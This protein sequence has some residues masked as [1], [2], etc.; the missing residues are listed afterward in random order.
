MGPRLGPAQHRLGSPTCFPGD[1]RDGYL[2][3]FF[4][5]YCQDGYCTV[6]CYTRYPAPACIQ[7]YKYAL[8]SIP[9]PLPASE[10]PLHTTP[11]HSSVIL[12]VGEL[13]TRQLKG[14]ICGLCI[15]VTDFYCLE[16]AQ[17]LS[18][19]YVHYVIATFMSRVTP[20]WGQSFHPEEKIKFLPIPLL[21]SVYGKGRRGGG[22]VHGMRLQGV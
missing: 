17:F 8:H 12:P 19:N 6:T 10:S 13:C 5:F 4:S 7:F 16:E 2:R 11:G 1:I 20:C 22:P 3:L 15:F 18:C 21:L 14:N 9:L